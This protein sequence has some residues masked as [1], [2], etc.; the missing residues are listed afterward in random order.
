MSQMEKKE[1]TRETAFEYLNCIDV[2]DV[3]LWM[4]PVFIVDPV[5][6]FYFVCVF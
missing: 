5:L 4:S 1:V 3:T 2:F 6:D